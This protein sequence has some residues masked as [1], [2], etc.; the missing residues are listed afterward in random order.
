LEYRINAASLMLLHDAKSID[1]IAE[2]NGFYDRAHFSKVFRR[3]RHCG[4]ATY[5]KRHGT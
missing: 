1:E 5:R 4:P 2:V 3:Y